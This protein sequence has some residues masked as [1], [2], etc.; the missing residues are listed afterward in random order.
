MV[1]KIIFSSGHEILYA[2]IAE[3]FSLYPAS[4]NFLTTFLEFDALKNIA[5]DV[6]CL[7][8]RARSSFSNISVLHGTLVI[9][10]VCVVPGEVSSI[11]ILADA[12]NN[13]G[14]PGIISKSRLFFL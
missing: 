14:I 6:L 3:S 8:S 1:V 11:P 2:I 7:A 13:D 10:M 4:S 12:A 9:I 5:I